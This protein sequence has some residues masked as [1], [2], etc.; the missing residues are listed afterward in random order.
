MS[1]VVIGAVVGDSQQIQVPIGDRIARHFAKIAR[2]H[3]RIRTFYRIA[4]GI[5]EPGVVFCRQCLL[6]PLRA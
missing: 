2:R 6:V 3:E 5:G 4:G 1:T